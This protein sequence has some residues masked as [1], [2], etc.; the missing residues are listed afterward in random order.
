[1]P[2]TVAWNG[3]LVVYA[4]GYVAFNEPIGIPESQ[5]TLPDGTSLPTLLNSLGFAFAMSSYSTNGLAVLQ[6]IQDSAD[7]VSIFTRVV[8]P[9]RR[10]YLGGPS[11]GGII[12]ALSIERHPEVWHAGLAAC[13]A[14]GSFAMEIGY[15]GDFRVLFDYFFP[16]ILPGTAAQIPSDLI[17]NWD[18]IYV[19]KIKAAVA[20]NPATTLQLLRV[21]KAPTG[22]E[23]T[24]IEETVESILWYSTF[25]TNDATSKLGGLPYDNSTRVYTG[26]SDDAR[27]NS[28]V[29]RFT[30]SPAALN[31]MKANYETTGKLTRPLVSIHTTGDQILPIWH[32]SLFNLKNLLSGTSNRHVYLPVVRYGHCNLNAFEVLVA[33]VGVLVLDSG[34]QVSSSVAN[35]LPANQR[36]AFIKQATSLGLLK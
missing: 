16:G 35:V 34:Q 12:T 22:Q 17:A 7:V 25:S 32:E 18:S 27:L 6:G 23:P 3:S 10:V 29:A 30:A 28:T 31:E 9:P 4:H 21:S 24:T 36:A 8:G 15:L 1:M 19:P 26:S 33:F 5:L 20:A 14:I 2:D 11:E 13:G